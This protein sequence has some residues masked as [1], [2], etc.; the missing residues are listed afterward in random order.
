MIIY[1]KIPHLNH[2][3]GLRA[4]SVLIVLAFHFFPST[5]TGGYIGVDIFFV[6]SGYLITLI[7]FQNKHPNLF[8]F[9]YSFIGRRIIRILPALIL[10]MLT[11]LIFG[12][13]ALF[14]EEFKSLSRQIYHS[15][16]FTLNPE[17]INSNYFDNNSIFKPLMHL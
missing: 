17:L 14:A 6:I 11:A 3:T 8:L 7:L 13:F 9:Y 10:V 16:L 5:F 12:W 1:K 2:I 4:Y 15:S